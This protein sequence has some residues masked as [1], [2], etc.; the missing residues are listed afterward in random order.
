MRAGFLE[1]TT[2]YAKPLLIILLNVSLVLWII[3]ENYLELS[4]QT[5][6]LKI[7][8]YVICISLVQSAI[9]IALERRNEKIAVIVSHG[10]CGIQFSSPLP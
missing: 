4:G 7:L 10:L 5:G 9:L 2:R 6:F 8:S 1:Q 3:K